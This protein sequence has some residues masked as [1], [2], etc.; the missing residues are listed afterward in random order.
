MILGMEAHSPL[1][2]VL[3]PGLSQE[4]L[5]AIHESRVQRQMLAAT[6][7]WRGPAAQASSQT[8]YRAQRLTLPDNR[9][10]YVLYPHAHTSMGACDIRE[11]QVAGV[12]RIQQDSKDAGRRQSGA[13]AA[14]PVLASVISKIVSETV[15]LQAQPRAHKL[16]AQQTHPRDYQ[17]DARASSAETRQQ[18]QALDKDTQIELVMNMN[19]RE[20]E[21]KEE[22][23]LK[24]VAISVA[25]AV[26]G[27]VS[28]VLP[29]QLEPGL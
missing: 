13:A 26:K 6:R 28:K 14:T 27:I 19:M 8:V 2:T 22:A 21:G 18:P 17:R 24:T 25:V 11:P 10:N 29:L 23:F 5:R 15:A 7:T 16:A 3:R 12:G 1:G 20:I 9:D 4:E